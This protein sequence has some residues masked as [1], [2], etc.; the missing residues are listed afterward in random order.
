M[1][2]TMTTEKM[3]AYGGDRLGIIKDF[4]DIPDG[5]GGLVT[6]WT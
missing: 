1:I 3:M 5:A 2:P 6:T 4:K